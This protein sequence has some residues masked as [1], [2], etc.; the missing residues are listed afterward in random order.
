MANRRDFLDE[1]IQRIPLAEVR[2]RL[3]LAIKQKMGLPPVADDEEE[4]EF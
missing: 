2:D 3:D 4:I 1:I